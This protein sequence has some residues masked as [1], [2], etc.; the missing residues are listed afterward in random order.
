QRAGTR[1]RG[2]SVREQEKVIQASTTDPE[3]GQPQRRA[4]PLTREQQVLQRIERVRRRKARLQ[5][6]RITMAHGAGGKATLTLIEA[7]FLEAFATRCW[8]LW[9]IRQSS[10]WTVC[11][12]PSRRTPLWCRPS[13]SQVGTLA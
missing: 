13:F 4:E 2:D 10:T 11:A 3:L 5:E 1:G 9:R 7:L 6:E 12:W 8:R